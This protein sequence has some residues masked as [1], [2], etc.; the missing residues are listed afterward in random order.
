MFVISNTAGVIRQIATAVPRATG[1]SII[2]TPS[3][4]ATDMHVSE[5]DMKNRDTLKLTLRV[6]KLTMGV[7]ANMKPAVANEEQMKANV[8]AIINASKI[9]PPASVGVPPFVWSSAM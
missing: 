3:A 7:P 6:T 2:K 9:Y 5:L 4:K 8:V 1:A